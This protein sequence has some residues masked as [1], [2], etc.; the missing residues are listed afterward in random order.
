ML[1]SEAARYARWS[2]AIALTLAGIT[3]VVYL[4]RGYTSHVE[5]KHAPPPAPV[6]VTRQSAGITFKKFDEQNHVI[7]TVQA[8]KSTD[9][10]GED[11]TLLED[12]QITI[13]GKAG[14]RN[15][16][17]HTKSCQY[18]KETGG[19]TCS[20]DVQ[21]DLMSAADA[22]RVASNPV[23]AKSVTTRVETQGVTFDRKTGL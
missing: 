6:D 23:L 12:V 4:K 9:F 18:G 13:F 10:K 21:L 8:S 19:V 3:A 15:D 17:I 22:K 14:D 1:R 5:R 2:A 7:F 11:A 20:G 16:V